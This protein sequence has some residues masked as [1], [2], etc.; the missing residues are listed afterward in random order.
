MNVGY[1]TAITFAV[2]NAPSIDSKNG[3]TKVLAY[4][5]DIASLLAYIYSEDEEY[6]AEV[7]IKKI[8]S[9]QDY[10]DK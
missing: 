1:H 2:G 5:T 6:T 10:E 3:P 9:D 7:L 8:K 4:A